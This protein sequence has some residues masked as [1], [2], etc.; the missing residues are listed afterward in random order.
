MEWISVKD[1]K[2]EEFQI[3]WSMHHDKSIK[4]MEYLHLPTQGW[5]WARVY[6]VPDI[7]NGKWEAESFWDDEY[8]PTHWMPLPELP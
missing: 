5:I 6:S 4:M 8:E 2:P 1:K 3:V 7:H